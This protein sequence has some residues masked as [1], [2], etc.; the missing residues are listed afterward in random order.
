MTIAAARVDRR[1]AVNRARGIDV[2]TVLEALPV[3]G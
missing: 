1:R 2:A 3:P